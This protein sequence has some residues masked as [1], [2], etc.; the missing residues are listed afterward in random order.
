MM[1]RLKNGIDAG[2]VAQEAIVNGTSALAVVHIILGLLGGVHNFIF[3]Y[4]YYYW[5]AMLMNVDE[6]KYY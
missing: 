1:E 4:I 5:S 3:F 2:A 6:I